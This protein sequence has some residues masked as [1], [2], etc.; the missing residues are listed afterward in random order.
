MQD[1]DISSLLKY[2]AELCNISRKL[3]DLGVPTTAEIPSM[4]DSA[5]KVFEQQRELES[6]MA[7]AFNDELASSLSLL[8]RD[9]M[10]VPESHISVSKEIEEYIESIQD[11][12]TPVFIEV[13]EAMSKLPEKIH[14]ALLTLG[15]KGWYV[16]SK[17]PHASLFRLEQELSNGNLDEAEEV[18]CEYYEQRS[19]EIEKAIL[20]SFPERKMPIEAAFRAHRNQEYFLS[21]PVLLAQADGICGDIAGKYFFIKNNKKPQIAT[22][23]LSITK[24]KF[25]RM[26]FAPLLQ[27]L[28]I[29]ASSSEREDDFDELNR[30]MVLHGETSKYGTRTNS[31]KAISL[32][33][34]ISHVLMQTKNIPN[35]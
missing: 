5:R 2:E 18:L 13:Q 19:S 21:I 30:H 15:R 17:F 4:S 3:Y 32:I 24:S 7:E 20:S 9:H 25:E 6:A 16:D 35:H 14:K 26:F 23:I 33:G 22:Y 8:N 29:N 31:I 12:I 1:C 11:Y 27:T 28:P 10:L 34:Y